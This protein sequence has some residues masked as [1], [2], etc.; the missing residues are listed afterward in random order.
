MNLE[1]ARFFGKYL[2]IVVSVFWL[3]LTGTEFIDKQSA[4]IDLRNKAL[5]KESIARATGNIIDF[6]GD[7][8]PWIGEE[9]L[10]TI[11][12]R[13]KITNNGNL[14]HIY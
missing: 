8:Q 5:S 10:C 6:R 1:W 12:G 13:Y 9:E 11:T 4:E 3:L 2:T 14:P 7:N